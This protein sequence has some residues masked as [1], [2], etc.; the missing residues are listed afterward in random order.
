MR[1]TALAILAIAIMPIGGCDQ[2]V[3]K[4]DK[5]R[6]ESAR[7]FPRADRPVA[8]IESTRWSNEESRDRLNEADDI[9]NRAGIRPGM[10]VA[11]IGA[12]EGYY[13]VR[14]DRRVGPRGRVLA[15]DILPEVLDSMALWVVCQ[16]F[17]SA[18][19]P[20]GNECGR[21]I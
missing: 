12:G 21:T 17:I 6:P 20:V 11:D 1:P 16:K 8:H 18:E 15:Q 10:T 7:D 19:L 3:S 4:S 2:L 14:L 5:D 13:T 9:M